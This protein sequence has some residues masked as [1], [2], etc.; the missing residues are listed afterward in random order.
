LA[1]AWDGIVGACAAYPPRW[2][3]CPW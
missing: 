1:C 2:R 3:G